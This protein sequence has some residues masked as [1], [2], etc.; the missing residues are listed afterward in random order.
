MMMLESLG[1]PPGLTDLAGGMLARLPDVLSEPPAQPGPRNTSVP[2][3]EGISAEQLQA[4]F[5]DRN[6][7]GQP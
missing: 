5:A 7:G 1:L 4:L 6:T 2:Q 3:P